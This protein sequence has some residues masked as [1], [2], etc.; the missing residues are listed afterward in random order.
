MALEL[1]IV[2]RVVNIHWDDGLAVEFWPDES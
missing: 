2:T 1:D